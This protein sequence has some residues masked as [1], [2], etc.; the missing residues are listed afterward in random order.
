MLRS[1]PSEARIA[2]QR[3]I[4]LSLGVWSRQ[5]PVTPNH[6]I[7]KSHNWSQVWFWYLF[8]LTL[9]QSLDLFTL[10]ELMSLPPSLASKDPSNQ[11]TFQWVSL[12]SK[13][14]FHN[15]ASPTKRSQFQCIKVATG[16]LLWSP[17]WVGLL[18]SQCR[19][20]EADLL[21]NSVQGGCPTQSL[22]TRFPART[23]E[24]N[25]VSLKTL[26]A[27]LE[28]TWSSPALG[29]SASIRTS[30]VNVFCCCC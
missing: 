9:P 24:S 6:S 25:S 2:K 8:F 3:E 18:D 14:T 23:S 27:L 20:E 7:L 22:F 11:W 16:W 5:A 19:G 15:P 26:Q 30:L 12:L 17:V 21:T 10:A 1:N 28:D 29:D 4:L 13:L